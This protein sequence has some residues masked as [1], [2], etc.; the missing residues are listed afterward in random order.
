MLTF[1]GT[2]S[3]FNTAEGNTSAYLK[4]D[5]S[6]LLIDCGSDVYS[7][8]TELVA[9]PTLNNFFVLVTHVHTD[10]VGSLGS[11]IED[12]YFN[13]GTKVTVLTPDTVRL[14]N[15]LDAVGVDSDYYTLQKLDVDEYNVI[16]NKDLGDVIIKPYKVDH[17]SN[18]NSYA[19]V[20]RNA[21][22]Q[23][24]Y[25]GNAN[26]IPSEV[27]TMLLAGEFD[28]FYQEVTSLD[29]VNN[30]HMNYTE[31]L[32][33]IPVNNR[34]DVVLMHYDEDFDKVAA[35]TAGFTVA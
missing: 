27:L 7:R 13:K 24:Y 16:V 25:S 12:V 29:V 31:L 32:D 6:I 19:Y 4:Q 14:S 34:T 18:M 10:H 15:V 33:L 35:S 23:I 3:A 20:I 9:Y 17:V 8:L 26:E 1:L 28:K 22:Q 5:D 2:G 21:G 11:L 30:P